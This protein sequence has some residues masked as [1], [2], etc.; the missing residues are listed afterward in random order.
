MIADFLKKFRPEGAFVLTAIVPD[1]KTETRTFF[2]AEE[3]EV[4]AI[5]KNMTKNIYFHVNKTREPLTSKAAKADIKSVQFLHVDIDPRPGDDFLKERDRILKLLTTD[6]PEGIPPPSLIVD[7]GGG[8]QAFWRLSEE[9]V[10]DGDTGKAVEIESYNRAL[11]IKFGADAC[12]DISRIMRL[13][14]TINRPNKKKRAKGRIEV[15]AKVQSWNEVSYPLSVFTPA[16][17]L[18]D[19]TNIPISNAT[20][21]I[22]PD[23]FSVLRPDDLREWADKNKKEL[24]EHTLALIVTGED[25][26]YPQRYPSRSEALFRVVCDLARLEMPDQMIFDVITD[27]GNAISSSVREQRSWQAY[28][29][30]QIDRAHESI[31]LKAEGPSWDRTT[32]EGA[33]LP[34]YWN[35][36]TAL[37]LMGVE[38]R[39][40]KFKDRH[41]VGSYELQELAGDFSDHAE[42]ILRDEIIRKFSFD[43][44]A[45]NTSSAVLSICTENRFDSLIDHI[46]KL[47]QWDG[48]TRIN[49]W[50]S[51][52][53]GVEDSQYSREAG[54]AWMTASIVR[55]FE[56]GAKFDYML[57]LMGAQGVGKSTA[58]RVLAGDGFFSD[59]S[60]LH[61]R[62]SK[63]VLEVTAGVWIL[64]CAELDGMSK[65]DVSTLKAAIARQA[66]TGRLAYARNAISVPRR[67]VLAGT[68]N[69]ERFLQDTTGN[70]R[71]WPVSV[72][73]IDLAGLQKARNQLWAE[74]YHIYKSGKYELTLSKQALIGASMAQSQRQIVDEGYY[75][76]L[77]DLSHEIEKWQ[78]TW[79]VRVNTIYRKLG[80]PPRD[81]N[82][83]LT[84]KVKEAMK[85][86][87]WI[88]DGKTK[89]V[90]GEVCRVYEWDGT[91]SPGEGIIV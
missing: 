80:V 70:R 81:R 10:I 51:D 40:D 38:C 43:P 63:E 29:Q 42:R 19:R 46:H 89:R 6:L 7:S 66:D 27:P 32:K 37:L 87:G 4:W 17:P 57:V 52:F 77:E 64:E 2:K 62:D 53:L 35:T 9:I 1:G 11:E 67:F 88:T 69:E 56:P 72:G 58:L 65:R 14:A 45:I 3:A 16:P 90:N 48:I 78:G 91:G 31:R 39:Y 20:K 47:P 36:R 84:R 74:A 5:Q 60:F 82:G 26:I 86:H 23:E 24:Q 12:H 41:I 18:I 33:P 71:F 13:P 30:R 59:A 75:E 21:S 83:L 73:A 55:A 49:T 25:P 85:A 68:T 50:L 79:I 15:E 61:A 8:Y 54:A 44:G 22:S 28:A 34:S 76:Q